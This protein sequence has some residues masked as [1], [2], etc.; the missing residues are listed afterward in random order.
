MKLFG[1]YDD[2]INAILEFHKGLKPPYNW[3]IPVLEFCASIVIF[4]Y[5]IKFI[6]RK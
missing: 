1:Y 3:T 5:V 4:H 6:P 2:W